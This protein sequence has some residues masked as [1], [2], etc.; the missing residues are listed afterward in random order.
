[1]YH[2]GEWHRLMSRIDTDGVMYAPSHD[3][4][5]LDRFPDGLVAAA[6]R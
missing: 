1:M 2:L 3:P 4:A 6:S 5:V